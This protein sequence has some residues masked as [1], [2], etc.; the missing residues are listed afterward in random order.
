MQRKRNQPEQSE[1]VTKKH[2]NLPYP[3]DPWKAPMPFFRSAFIYN[4]L[5]HIVSSFPVETTV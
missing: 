5:K 1:K 3:L 2:R 4:T